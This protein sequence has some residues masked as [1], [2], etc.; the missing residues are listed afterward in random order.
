MKFVAHEVAPPLSQWIESIFHYQD[1]QPDHSI[2]RVVPTGHTFILIELDGFE[3]ST[4]DNSSLKVRGKFRQAWLSGPQQNFLSISAHMNSEMF[5][6]QFKPYG[7]YMFLKQ[8]LDELAERVV[9]GQEVLDGAAI[10]LRDKLLAAESS[11]DK[12]QVAESWLASRYDASCAP[13]PELLEFIDRLQAEP[14]AKLNQ[15]MGAYG[16]SQKHLIDQFKRYVGLTPK[17][18]QRIVRFNE[19]LAT[20]QSEQQVNWS[21]VAHRCGYAD[22]SHFIREFKKFSGFNP[23]AFIRDGHG[24]D[25]LNFFPIDRPG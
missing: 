16:G 10:E 13:A 1:F 19:L 5:V 22:Q 21:D 6:V 7:A 17:R 9:P 18:Y 14:V 2:E 20:M 4:F 25:G 23:Q 24:E 3:R 15:L 12:F 11:A 8:R